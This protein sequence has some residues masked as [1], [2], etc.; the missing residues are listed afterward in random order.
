MRIS[1]DEYVTGCRNGA[2]LSKEGNTTSKRAATAFLRNTL[3]SFE[4][5]IAE[6][7]THLSARPGQLTPGSA[8]AFSAPPLAMEVRNYSI[9]R[10]RR[11]F[12]DAWCIPCSSRA[13]PFCSYETQILPGPT[14]PCHS[15][16]NPPLPCPA[17]ARSLCL[18]DIVSPC[19]PTSHFKRF[20]CLAG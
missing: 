11:E 8:P 12:L 6:S 18:P 17:T 13:P 16:A 1:L 14:N 19:P 15:S 4:D 5:G 20:L 7:E 3:P 2:L 9:F 10:D